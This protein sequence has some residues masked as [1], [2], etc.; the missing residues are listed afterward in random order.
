MKRFRER[1]RA[2]RLCVCNRPLAPGMKSCIVCIEDGRSRSKTRYKSRKA[3][4]LCPRCAGAR[5]DDHTFCRR[6]REI[7]LS[8]K[9][10]RQ[11]RQR[12]ER[13]LREKARE[14]EL[15]A[16]LETAERK[17]VDPLPNMRPFAG[18]DRAAIFARFAEK[19]E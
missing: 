5:A 7:A 1:Q 13:R 3:K 6:C 12:R 19:D 2:K 8:R 10:A 11:A 16:A 4:G 9:R 18:V 17:L 14:A 15:L